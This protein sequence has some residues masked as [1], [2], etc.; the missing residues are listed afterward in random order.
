[1]ADAQK[2]RTKANHAKIRAQTKRRYQD[3]YSGTVRDRN[4]RGLYGIGAEDWERLFASQGKR[5]PICGTDTPIGRGWGTDHD[6]KTGMI[7]GILC[8]ECNTLLAKA[9]D[10]PTILT[11]AIGYLVAASQSQRLTLAP[12]GKKF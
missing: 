8:Q 6:H 1:V 11:N 2:I 10:D 3:Y 9:R 5:C 4:L 12:G 7:R